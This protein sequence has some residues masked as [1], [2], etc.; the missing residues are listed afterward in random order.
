M[1][2]TKIE[3]ATDTWNPVTR[4]TSVAK[5]GRWTGD[6]VCH[7]VALAE[8]FHWKKPKTVFVCGMSDLFHS[9]VP[10]DFI[11]K[12]FNVMEATPWHTYRVLTKHPERMAYFAERVWKLQTMDPHLSNR[13]WP[14]NVWAGTSVESHNYASRLDCLARVPARVRFVI[15]NDK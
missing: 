10:W 9:K 14:S 5:N 12:V 1:A 3:W 4:W 15:V 13:M 6:I 2:D 11:V 8:P 7:D